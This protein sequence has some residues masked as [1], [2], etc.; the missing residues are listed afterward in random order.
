MFSGR[1]TLTSPARRGLTI[2]VF[3]ILLAATPKAWAET[4]I[5]KDVARPHGVQRTQAEKRAAIGNCQS[6]GISN[7]NL[8]AMEACMR[9]QGWAVAAIRPDASDPPG[10]T[11]DDM[12]QKPNGPRR[13][14]AELNAD[15]AICDPTGQA[16]PAS[17]QVKR[18]MS[19]RGWRLS[20]VR[21]DPVNQTYI[22][23]GTGD[24]CR[25][26]G[27]GSELCW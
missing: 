18:C 24:T 11:Y 9:R 1:A 17:P 25:H 19:A 4:V 27:P 8:P 26:L 23:P 15:T 22:D 3:C 20:F 2:S 16:S 21:P 7:D 5:F 13:S 12:W 14:Q 10:A 6:Q